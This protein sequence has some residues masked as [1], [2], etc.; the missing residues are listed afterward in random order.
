MSKDA[1]ERCWTHHHSTICSSRLCCLLLRTGI[2]NTL[3]NRLSITR[4]SARCSK[5]K[6]RFTRSS[7]TSL[8]ALSVF[9]TVFLRISM[10][11]TTTLD[12]DDLTISTYTRQAFC[13]LHQCHF[14]LY[15]TRQHNFER[16]L[17]FRTTITQ[18]CFPT[19][20]MANVVRFVSDVWIFIQITTFHG[21][22]F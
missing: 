10:R 8:G 1:A 19:M 22:I 12:S 20:A 11:T 7:D 9:E 2:F 17:A 4:V 16:S 13:Y 5:S 18:H 3:Y 6:H 14:P 15:R 21:V